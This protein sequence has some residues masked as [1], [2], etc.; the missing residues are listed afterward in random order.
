MINIQDKIFY[1]CGKE[2]SYAMYVNGM[3]FLQH[4]Y[5]G[6]KTD[7][8]TVRRIRQ[9]CSKS[10]PQKGDINSDFA[11][12][13]M[14]SEIGGYF[15]HGDFREPSVILEQADG[16][17]ISRFRYVSHKLKYGIAEIK[18][19][20]YARGAGETLAVTLKDDFSDTEI[21][22][23]YTVFE[24]CDVI[25]RNVE[26]KNT[27]KNS[28]ILKKVFSCCVDLPQNKYR[29]L[30]LYG[31]WADERNVE[32]TEIGRGTVKLQSLRGGSSHQMNPFATIL[33]DNCTEYDGECYGF[34][35][36]YSGNFAIT[37]EVDYSG[38][39]RLQ[40]GINDT[41]FNW[42]LKA[43]ECFAA[44]QAALCYS[45]SGIGELSRSYH[46]FIRN[47]IINPDYVHKQRP[48]VVNNWEA[49]YFDFDNEKLFSIIDEAAKLGI[50]TFV[51]DDGWFGKRN[52]E[53]SGLGDWYVN[54][55]KLKGGLKSLIERCK[56][57][58]MK[59]GLWFE[60]EAIIEDSDLY[61]NHPDWAIGKDGIAPAH[62]RNQLLLD[63]TR[64]EI[65]DYIYGCIAKILDENDISYVKWDFNRN[66]TEFYSRSLNR[67]GEFAHRYILG[68]YDLAERLTSKFPNV[69]FEGCA[70]GGGRFDAG[71]LYYFPQI[72]TSD[73]TDA[74][75][76]M[77][78]QYGTSM[79][80]PISA[81]S[82]HVSACPNHQTGRTTPLET[83]F[84]V[85]S[86]GA[87]GY[88][89][90]L[91]KLTDEE[92]AQIKTQ[93]ER[94]KEISKLVLSG[95]LYRLTNPSDG[96][97][98]EM[99]VSKDKSNACIVYARRAENSPLR[100][101]KLNGLDKDKLYLINDKSQFMG[102]MLM[103]QGL[104]LPALAE[105]QSLTFVLREKI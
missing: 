81:M 77:R 70:G 93:V 53:T 95:D 100:L 61:R 35:L 34:Q 74:I 12:D 17:T 27:G 97:F 104:S 46:D 55:K 54:D 14:P 99:I 18:G 39:L 23:N 32:I 72:W 22:L 59:F 73:N 5:Y 50:D 19:M 15:N 76:R 37:A 62:W 60:P 69:L 98:C 24:D 21:V 10:E 84:A 49:T 71:M 82:C 7:F 52:D 29:L 41:N 91:T 79:C 25:V 16:A 78:I 83:R 58:G 65:V 47:H 6:K 20:P 75:D 8:E 2:Y 51:L 48:I 40:G 31:K 101:I 94:Y 64:R 9:E 45:N 67:Q 33:K 80:Y 90:D 103:E 105:N 92:K 28:V 86:L 88:E 96:D 85:A 42:E 30:R 43:G 68:V 63:F 44:P 26:I 66:I 3:G 1:L 36:I 13:I 4:A 89:L 38:G 11:L 57:N 102:K 56:Q 87:F